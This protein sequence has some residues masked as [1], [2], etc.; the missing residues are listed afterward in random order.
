[1][2]CG[3]GSKEIRN[4]SKSV[5]AELKSEPGVDLASRIIAG[6]AGLWD[7]RW[8]L[9]QGWRQSK[10]HN[11]NNVFAVPGMSLPQKLLIRSYQSEMRLQLG[12]R[13]ESRT[14]SGASRAVGLQS[15]FEPGLPRPA[16]DRLAICG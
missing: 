4:P 11:S 16:K 7:R 14:I 5:D 8:A 12:F 3:A 13:H 6:N 2:A 9:G 10:H 15:R 1:M